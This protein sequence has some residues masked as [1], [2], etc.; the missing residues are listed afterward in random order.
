[1]GLLILDFRRYRGVSEKK[2]SGSEEVKELCRCWR[3]RGVMVERNTM[4]QVLTTYITYP[5]NRANYQKK[6]K[7][8]GNIVYWQLISN[9]SLLRKRMRKRKNLNGAMRKNKDIYPFWRP[10][11]MWKK[12]SYLMTGQEEKQT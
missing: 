12:N 2:I 9:N 4:T 8:A 11:D 5:G 3:L 10:E 7:T 6:I 1:M